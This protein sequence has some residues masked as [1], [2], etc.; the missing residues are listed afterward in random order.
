MLICFYQ[1]YLP[2]TT[3]HHELASKTFSTAFCELVSKTVRKYKINWSVGFCVRRCVCGMKISS[4]IH[5]DLELQLK[6]DISF[7]VTLISQQ[8]QQ[9]KQNTAQNYVS[10]GINKASSFIFSKRW[11]FFFCWGGGGEEGSRGERNA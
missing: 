2:F 9:Q 5:Q 8:Q 7:F 10:E 4:V 6:E 1:K 3:A 11:D